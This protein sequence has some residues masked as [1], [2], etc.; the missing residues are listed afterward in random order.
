MS[1]YGRFQK[2]LA[3]IR[4]RYNTRVFSFPMGIFLL[5]MEIIIRASKWVVGGERWQTGI[6][7]SPVR[8]YMDDLTLVTTTVP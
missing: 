5:A 7:I 6:Q 1:K 3:E 8:A 2:R 4:N